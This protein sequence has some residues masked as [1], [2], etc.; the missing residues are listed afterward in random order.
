[1][2]DGGPSG[3]LRPVVEPVG[4]VAGGLVA[5]ASGAVSTAGSLMRVV[6]L[7]R[8]GVEGGLDS[9]VRTGGAAVSGRAPSDGV[10]WVIDGG[11]SVAGSRATR[12]SASSRGLDE[13]LAALLPFLLDFLGMVEE[14]VWVGFESFRWFGDKKIYQVDQSHRLAKLVR[15]WMDL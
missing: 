8:T 1:M 10:F 6:E 13:G 3:E 2:T 12:G 7:S 14:G 15:G 9:L 4:T 11:R 5:G